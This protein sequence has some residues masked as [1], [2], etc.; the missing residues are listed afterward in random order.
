METQYIFKS[1]GNYLGFISN[2]NIFSNNGVYLGWLE[3]NYAWDV[4]GRFL[5]I[6]TDIS[7]H[8]YIILNQ[9]LINPI[10]RIPHSAP[11]SPAIPAPHA[12]IMPIILP[13]GHIDS[14]E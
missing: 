13:V 3:G 9:L 1:N 7:N 6:L 4:T 8:K 11:A 10:P 5:G 2:G 14:F 12:N